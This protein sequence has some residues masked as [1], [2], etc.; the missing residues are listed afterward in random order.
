ME[1]IAYHE[2]GHAVMLLAFCFNIEQATIVGNENAGGHATHTWVVDMDEMATSDSYDEEAQIAFE[3]GIM[4]FL[5][6]E[7]AQKRFAPNSTDE[8]HAYSDRHAIAQLFDAFIGDDEELRNA[9]WEFLELRTDRL[10]ERYWNKVEWIAKLLME[11]KTLGYEELVEAWGD[12]ELPSEHRGKHLSDSERMQIIADSY[13]RI[14]EQMQS[15]M[16]LCRKD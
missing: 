5:A 7:I 4:V 6:G 13:W 14:E 1:Y 9:Y 2:A 12:A 3:H 11:H 8:Y 15:I 16:K 10:L